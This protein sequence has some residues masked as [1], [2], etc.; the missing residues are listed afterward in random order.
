[1]TWLGSAAQYIGH[2]S[3]SEMGPLW[4]ICLGDG[5]DWLQI[6]LDLNQP[7]FAWYMKRWSRASS[8][9]LVQYRLDDWLLGRVHSWR[10]ATRHHLGRDWSVLRGGHGDNFLFRLSSFSVCCSVSRPAARWFMSSQV[11]SAVSSLLR[12]AQARRQ[13]RYISISGRQNT[14]TAVIITVYQKRRV[15]HCELTDGLA[16]GA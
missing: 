11:S 4:V 15:T 2:G 3:L 13:L 6:V 9:V 10:Y 14:C 1:M 7:G 16:D 8:P 5:W 12:S